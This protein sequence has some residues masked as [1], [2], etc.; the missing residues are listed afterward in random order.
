MNNIRSVK[1]LPKEERVEYGRKVEREIINTLNSKGYNVVQSTIK[2]DKIDKI[3][4][5][6]MSPGMVKSRPLQI[7]Y[8]DKPNKY[9]LL[10]MAYLDN[11]KGVPKQINNKMKLDGRDYV[12]RS[13][14]YACYFHNDKAI[15]L[16]ETTELKKYAIDATMHLL[17]NYINNNSVREF[18]APNGNKAVIKSDPE[19]KRR[20]ILFLCDS[21]NIQ[22][23]KT[24]HL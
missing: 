18:Q 19:S 14:L 7:K 9:I 2:E 11:K 13:E 23:L 3:D 22:S 20:K 21:N 5:H 8:R 10:E 16:C 4:A 17:Y 24:I 6:F 1:K 12:G 15:Q